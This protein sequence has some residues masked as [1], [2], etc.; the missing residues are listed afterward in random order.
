MRRNGQ[1]HGL[2]VGRYPTVGSD[3]GTPTSGGESLGQNPNRSPH[4]I[5]S[6][7]RE[8]GGRGGGERC[9]VCGGEVRTYVH[10]CVPVSVLSVTDYFRFRL[11][12]LV[13]ESPPEK[14]RDTE[15]KEWTLNSTV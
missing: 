10:V 5:R 13:L 2:S 3:T 8:K 15:S 7:L 11:S 9:R 14:E 1:C 6:R 12:E 4:E